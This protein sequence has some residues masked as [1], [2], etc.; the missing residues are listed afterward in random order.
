MLRLPFAPGR[1]G[2][3]LIL[4]PQASVILVKIGYSKDIADRVL[5]LGGRTSPRVYEGGLDRN[6]PYAGII[7]WRLWRINRNP[8]GESL[9]VLERR[10]KAHYQRLDDDLHVRLRALLNLSDF[11]PDVR[12]LF[13]ATEPLLATDFPD[14]ASGYA[15]MPKKG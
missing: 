5:E 11:L 9:D 10:L 13:L 1:R 12:E 2:P 8:T 6:P 4:V 14:I 15:M 7:D 3:S